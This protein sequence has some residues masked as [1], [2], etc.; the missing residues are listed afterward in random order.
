MELII[1]AA[2]TLLLMVWFI[3]IYNELTKERIETDEA[4]SGIGSML[5]QR[6]DVI[7]SLVE[8]VKGYTGHEHKT[9][10][11]VIQWRNKSAIAHSPTE[12]SE[13]ELGLQR[14]IAD[15]YSVSEQYPDLKANENFLLL[16]KQ[17]T[18]YEDSIS[19][20][21]RYYNGVVREYNQ[22]ISVFPKVLVAK[23]FGFEK[24]SFFQEIES[25]HKP[26]II[27]F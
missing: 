15:F 25:A 13:S 12:M 20:S 16:Q 14:S 22:S 24:K 21:R 4:W 18:A 11:E 26:P 23:L 6:N 19:K 9:L 7:P 27:K 17:L 10:T 3:L 8:I 2:I 5:Q 1:S